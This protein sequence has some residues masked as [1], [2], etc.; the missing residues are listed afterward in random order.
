MKAA[1]RK[2]FRSRMWLYRRR[3]KDLSAEEQEELEQLFDAI[4]DLELP[5]CV[6]EDVAEIFDTAKNRV[7]AASRLEELRT[8]V[9]KEPEL[10]EFFG[11]FDRWRDGILAYFDDR[12]TSGPVEGLNTKARVIRAQLRI[13]D[14]DSLWKR[15][16]LDVNRV[17]RT[18]RR[19][20][21]ELH[22]LTRAIQAKFAGYYAQNGRAFAS[23]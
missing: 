18:E 17:V 16:V 13:E 14:A 8:V 20:V 21:S 7:E 2:K 4:P 5:Y 10:L 23:L 15:L 11:L 1:E 3:R 22:D 9:A 19:T 6:R 12:E